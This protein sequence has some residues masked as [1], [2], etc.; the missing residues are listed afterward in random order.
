MHADLVF[1]AAR[2]GP[3]R[4]DISIF[5]VEKGTPG[6]SVGR[7]LDKTGW[8][9]SDT[10]ELHFDACRVPASHLLGASPTRAST[11]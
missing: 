6:F 5:A 7:Q 8:R 9:C 1:V 11:R 4:R 10:A 2:T 3:G